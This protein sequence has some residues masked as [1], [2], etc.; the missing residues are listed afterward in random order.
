ML[1][2]DESGPVTR[3]WASPIV[4]VLEKDGSLR[5]SVDYHRLNAVTVCDSNLIPSMDKFINSL[6]KA[7][8]FSTLHASSSY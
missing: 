3:E 8:V 2:V 1:R 7:Q 5:L 6:G 4:F